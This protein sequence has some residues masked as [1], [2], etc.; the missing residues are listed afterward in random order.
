VLI[1]L[2]LLVVYSCKHSIS[3]MFTTVNNKKIISVSRVIGKRTE[4]I[5]CI[6]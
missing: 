1:K 2:T 6:R 4:K 3:W 5:R